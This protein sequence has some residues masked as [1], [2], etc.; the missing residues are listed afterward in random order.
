MSKT[1]LLSV[2]RWQFN[3]FK[4]FKVTSIVLF[5]V[6]CFLTVSE[7]VIPKF[8][9]IIID[10]VIPDKNVELLFRCIIFLSIFVVL[11]VIATFLQN[12]YERIIKESVTSV[13]IQEMIEQNYKLGVAYFT[14]NSVGRTLSM[15]TTDIQATTR[16]YGEIA[17]FLLK[18][19]VIISICVVMLLKSDFRLIIIVMICFALYSAIRPSINKQILKYL[20][21]QAKSKY[22]FDQKVYDTL[23]AFDDIKTNGH[24]IWSV[25][26]TIDKFK[27]YKKYKLSFLFWRFL[28]IGTNIV[29][30]ALANILFYV[31]CYFALLKG[32]M[33]LGSFVA[34]SFYFI[35]LYRYAV[36]AVGRMNDL[37][38]VS[39][40]A[41]RIYD[42]LKLEKDHK[43]TDNRNQL[44]SG[45]IE[46]K[47]VD[48]GYDG[49]NSIFNKFS[50][51]IEAGEQIAIVGSSG[52]G[53][54]TL[55]A[56]A[57]AFYEPY[58]GK[59]MLDGECVSNIPPE[60]FRNIV[61]VVFSDTY[62]FNTSIKENIRMG[63]LKI[64]MDDIIEACKVAHI[65]DEI[66]KL[67]DGYDTILG[68]DGISFS[69]GQKQRLSIARMIAHNPKVIF[70]DEPTSA[71]DNII[72]KHVLKSLKNYI[73][74]KTVLTITHKISTARYS[75]RIIFLKN[76]KIV[77]TSKYEELIEKKSE[78]YQWIKEGVV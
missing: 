28:S 47:D 67:S 72:E 4:L 19:V 32:S 8:I 2:I 59:V 78:F 55:F 63:N 60:E 26:G 18:V 42:Y 43:Y 37:V 31:V 10:N 23:H 20:E 29:F 24:R 68:K 77:E 57:L 52:S 74:G 9:N 71:L 35:I 73:K 27:I 25:G 64:E 34:N 14:D 76:G 50:M 62:M 56:L 70:M 51:K 41:E 40:H 36:I 54:S 65:H 13:L 21:E 38:N 48:F 16:T 53:K 22:D 58:G 39:K 46:F 69:G 45:E 75:D 49:N 3:H 5:F 6:T 61:G 12:K 44:R 15:F 33:T 66:S 17:P 11:I 1:K 30:G 7:L